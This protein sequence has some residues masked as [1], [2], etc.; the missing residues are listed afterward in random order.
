MDAVGGAGPFRN[1]GAPEDWPPS[2]IRWTQEITQ[3]VQVLGPGESPVRLVTDDASMALQIR[4]VA[5][6][7]RLYLERRGQQIQATLLMQT[8]QA[9]PMAVSFDVFV[10]VGEREFPLG[11][12]SIAGHSR[13]FSNFSRVL[14]DFAI[15]EDSDRLE[16][17]DILLRPNVQSV[18]RH[19]QEEAIWG[20][21]VVYDAVPVT[22]R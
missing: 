5:R 21:D 4:H 8:A 2:A 14:R 18:L 17:V 7:Q 15:D 19:S 3:Q 9:A 1:P 20:E 11:S 10:V 6:P 16:V 22:W 12:F 13:S